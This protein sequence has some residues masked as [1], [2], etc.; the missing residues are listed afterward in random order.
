[1]TP[2]GLWLAIGGAVR[3]RG[4]ACQDGCPTVYVPLESSTLADEIVS[5]VSTKKAQKAQKD[6]QDQNPRLPGSNGRSLSPTVR[7]GPGVRE[8]LDVRW[9]LAGSTSGR[10]GMCDFATSHC[11]SVELHERQALFFSSQEELFET[12]SHK[13]R[14][15][16]QRQHHP[17]R[18]RASREARV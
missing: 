3:S 12:T 11:A 13:N 4:N 15:R 14:L 18:P 8:Y 17:L 16:A 10:C 5:L 9:I 1:M 6:A 2:E 7:R